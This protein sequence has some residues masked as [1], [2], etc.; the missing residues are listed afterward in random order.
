MTRDEAASLIQALVGFMEDDED[1]H[2]NGLDDTNLDRFL[3]FYLRPRKGPR[4]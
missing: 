3:D 2:V 1:V 4:T